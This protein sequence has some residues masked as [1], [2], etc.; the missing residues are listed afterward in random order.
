MEGVEE[1]IRLLDPVNILKRGFSITFRNGKPIKSTADLL[2]G[3]KI[4]TQY[5]QGKTTSI[6]QEL[7]P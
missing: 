6:I 5:Y 7:E 2:T 3:D 1:K 4:E